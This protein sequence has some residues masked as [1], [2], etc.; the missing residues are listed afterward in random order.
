MTLTEFNNLPQDQQVKTIK[1]EGCFLYVRNEGGIDI[2][3]YQLRNFYAEV[4]FESGEA[5]KKDRI[6]IRSFDD[7]AS[8]DIYLQKINISALKELL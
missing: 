5:G 7:M 4:F 8:L 1:R 2:I 6:L 3:L